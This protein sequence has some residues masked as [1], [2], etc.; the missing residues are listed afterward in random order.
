MPIDYEPVERESSHSC[1][2]RMPQ[3]GQYYL[4]N[5]FEAYNLCEILIEKPILKPKKSKSFFAR[6]WGGSKGK[7]QEVTVEREFESRYIS[8]IEGYCIIAEYTK[9]VPFRDY[10]IM[11]EGMSTPMPAQEFDCSVTFCISMFE[12]DEVVALNLKEITD[13]PEASRKDEVVWI[14]LVFSKFPLEDGGLFKDSDEKNSNPNQEA[15]CILIPYGDVPE[16]IDEIRMQTLLAH[17]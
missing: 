9:E 8:F 4:L 6:W 7:T 1:Y 3:I 13:M 15:Q 10:G 17:T 2:H 14:E 12:L 11:G 5:C 16:L